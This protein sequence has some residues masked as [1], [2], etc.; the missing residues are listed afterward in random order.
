MLIVTDCIKFP[1][2]CQTVTIITVIIMDDRRISSGANYRGEGP[3]GPCPPGGREVPQLIEGSETASPCPFLLPQCMA[4]EA[5]AWCPGPG[6]NF[7]LSL[8]GR[9]VE[10]LG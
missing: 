2:F 7:P 6:A 10:A 1:P 9:V 3:E 5:G 4:Y 8:H